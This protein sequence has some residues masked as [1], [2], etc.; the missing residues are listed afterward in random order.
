MTTRRSEWPARAPH[1]NVHV[2]MLVPATP[3]IGR[4]F[5]TLLASRRRH[6]RAKAQCSRMARAL[7]CHFSSGTLPAMQMVRSEAA[8]NGTR[9]FRNVK[10]F[11][12]ASADASGDDLGPTPDM[13]QNYVR[14][15]ILQ[16]LHGSPRRGGTDDEESESQALFRCTF[17]VRNTCREPL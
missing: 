17:R 5:P 16:S 11:R 10:A 1:A 6:A 14:T 9:F 2:V 3:F 4:Q 7:S 8:P 15:G 13:P 12:T